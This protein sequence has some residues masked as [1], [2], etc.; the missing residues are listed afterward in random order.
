MKK[1]TFILLVL[2]GIM[3]IGCASKP[4]VITYNDMVIPE[5]E[6][7]KIFIAPN[8][9]VK[10][11]DGEEVAWDSYW[12]PLVIIINSGEHTIVADWHSDHF[13]INGEIL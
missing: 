3:F 10:Y 12:K 7:C 9:Y 1:A 13:R 2:F 5:G 8:V 4:T 11:F 6:Q